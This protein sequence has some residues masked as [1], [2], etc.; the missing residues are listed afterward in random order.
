[1]ENDEKTISGRKVLVWSICHKFRKIWSIK[2]AGK[3]KLRL[4]MSTVKSVLLHSA[5][6]W[7][8]TK[9]LQKQI[10]GCYTRMLRMT[11][12]VIWQEHV[13]HKELRQ[14]FSKVTERI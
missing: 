3:L 4:L 1:M 10:D 2:I 7:T 9:K 5:E 8:L 13:T 14:D 11:P 6:T 12:N